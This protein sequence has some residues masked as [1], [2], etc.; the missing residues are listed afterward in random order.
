MDNLLIEVRYVE[1]ATR[2]SPGRLTGTLLTY[3]EQARDRQELFRAGAL[4]WDDSGIAI[5]QQHVRANIITRAIPYL[6][7]NAVKIDA[8]L[9]NTTIGRDTAVNVREGILTG[10]SVEFAQAGLVAQMVGGIR[11]IR[12][13]RLVAAGL[14]DLASYAGSVVEIRH[15]LELSNLELVLPWL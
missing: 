14:V 15:V 1:D 6:D 11:E 9:P 7:G 5:N 3:D 12:S 4:K 2:Q 10:L 8:A 13:A